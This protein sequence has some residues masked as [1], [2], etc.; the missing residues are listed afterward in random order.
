MH[1]GPSG[2]IG[3]NVKI[4]YLHQYFHTPS[5]AGSTRSYEFARRWVSAGDEVHVVTSARARTRTHRGWRIRDVDGIMVHEIAVPYDNNMGTSARLRAFVEFAI[6]AG[7]RASA[8]QPDALFA[9]STPLTIAIPAAY[10]KFRTRAIL[11]FEVRDLWPAIPIA[12]GVIRDPL[13]RMVARW[14]ERFAYR[15]ADRI[16]ALSPGM[17]NGVS[18]TG[19]HANEVV[20]IPNGCDLDLFGSSN[21]RATESGVDV[22]KTKFANRT[23]CLYAGTI[24]RVN[25]LSY[26]VDV[27]AELRSIAPDVLFLLVGD[28]KEAD[29]VRMRAEDCGILNR[30]L[31]VQ[32]A[33]PKRSIAALFEACSVAFSVFIDLPEMW[34]NSANKFFDTLA[35]GRPVAINYRGWQ[36]DLIAHHDIGLVLPVDSPVVAARMLADFLAD[37]ETVSRCGRNARRLAETMFGRDELADKALGVLRSVALHK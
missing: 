29:L 2:D 3:W 12:M 23:M 11:V 25:G 19:V 15:I 13:S 7:P 24:G 6:R 1:T 36:A 31:Y 17:A 4:V 14:L 16:I 9:T 5:Q 37:R 22:W 30:T 34:H 35:A 21:S 27:A 10:A 33:L 18:A 20:V 8:I 28:G 26:I 32:G